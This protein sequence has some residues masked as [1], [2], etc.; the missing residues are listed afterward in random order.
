[1]GNPQ[2]FAVSGDL[3]T[4]WRALRLDEGKSPATT[5][6][7]LAYL[8]AVFNELARAGLWSLENPFSTVR[9]IRVDEDELAFLSP[10]QVSA[11]L[12][13]CDRSSVASTGL[14]T[15][16]ALATGARWSEAESLR[17]SQISPYR[18][19]HPRTKSGRRRALPISKDLYDL[20]QASRLPGA[21]NS[22]RCFASCYASFRSATKRAGIEL[23]QEQM[24][25]VLRLTF[26]S[27]FLGRGGNILV[28]QRALGHSSLSVTTRYSH[29]APDHLEG[30]VRL[31]RLS[32]ID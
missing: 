8:R 1:M 26:A 23:P 25:H 12:T 16:L 14:V 29:F 7:A 15:R 32:P 24:T 21:R 17:W 11:L 3:F 30:V 13:E 27:T 22:D 2:A 10:E 28:L 9:A 6:R 20:I 5:N 19:E 18:V 4:T 31:N